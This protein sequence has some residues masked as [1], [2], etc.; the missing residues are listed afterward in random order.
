[1]PLVWIFDRILPLRLDANDGWRGTITGVALVARGNMQAPL[2]VRS[3]N[4]PSASAGATLAETFAQWAAFR[5]R[6][7]QSTFPSMPNAPTSC[8]WRG[9]RSRAARDHRYSLARLRSRQVDWRVPWAIFAAGWILLDVRYRSISPGSRGCRRTLRGSQ[10]GKALAR[11]DAPLAALAQELRR[12]LPP[13]PAR[14]S[15]SATTGITLRV[16]HFLPV[17]RIAE[18]VGAER[19]REQGKPAPDRDAAQRR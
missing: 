14:V 9:G 8:R 12:A 18:P 13:P 7:T 1:M 11:D 10:R 19:E 5:S 3:L 4:L 15:C 2:E 17:Q 6:A 16:A